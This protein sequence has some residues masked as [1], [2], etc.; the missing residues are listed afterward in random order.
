MQRLSHSISITAVT[1][2]DLVS[3]WDNVS[4]SR[5]KFFRKLSAVDDNDD[6]TAASNALGAGL[7]REE[8]CKDVEIARVSAEIEC[9]FPSRGSYYFY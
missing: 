4:D 3:D 5:P 8:T 1:A 6:I 7:R 9:E 2:T